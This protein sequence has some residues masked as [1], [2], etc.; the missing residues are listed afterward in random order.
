LFFINPD[1]FLPAAG[2]LAKTVVGDPVKPG[3]ETCLAPK[4]TDMF[5][6]AQKSFLSEII[7]Q[8]DIG[9]GELSKQ[10]AHG[11]LMPPNQFSK[12]MLV[13][14]NKNSGDEVSIGQLHGR[15]LR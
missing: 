2:V 13:V 5:V 12:C 6:S 15:M 7:G 4:T 14:I 11:R 9:A 10:T 8:C 1:Q 3:R